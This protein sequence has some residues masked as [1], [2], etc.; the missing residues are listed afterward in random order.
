MFTDRN[1]EIM[2]GLRYE[3]QLELVKEYT[4]QNNNNSQK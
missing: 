1:V 4:K 2:T 3:K